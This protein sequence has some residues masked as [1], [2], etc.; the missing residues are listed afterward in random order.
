MS[1]LKWPIRT[2][3]VGESFVV[4]NPPPKQMHSNFARRARELGIKLSIRR[5]EW[6]NR[7]TPYV[8]TRVS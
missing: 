6:F 2:L 5:R 3:K 8:V 1:A 7:A 4:E